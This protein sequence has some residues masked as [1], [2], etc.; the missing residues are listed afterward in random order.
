MQNDADR[1]S[2]LEHIFYAQS[3]N[4]CQKWQ[5]YFLI[6][7]T[8]FARFRNKRLRFLEIGVSQGGSLDIWKTYFGSRASIVGVDIDPACRRFAGP[9]VEI[10]IG[11]QGD[12]ALRVWPSRSARSMRSSTTAGTGWTSRSLR[13]SISTRW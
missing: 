4:V 12:P 11:D 10:I 9:Q 6:Y 1:L 3:H 7:E 8:H 5:H 13:W 2:P